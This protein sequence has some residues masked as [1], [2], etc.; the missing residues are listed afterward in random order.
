MTETT[1][2]LFVAAVPPEHVLEHL[3]EVV[4]P[5]RRSRPDLTWVAPRLLHVT[6]TFMPH[7]AVAVADTLPEAITAAARD[8]PPIRLSIAG[9][10]RFDERVLWAGVAGDIDALTAT[11]D[12]VARAVVDAGP[13][14]RG[15]YR[16]HVSLARASGSLDARLGPLAEQLDGYEGPVWQAD[17]LAL[18]RSHLGRS[19]HHEL[20]ATI[21][22]QG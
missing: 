20:L 22:L 6:V 18:V 17:E 14:R 1:Q 10:G 16:P 12:A 19:A 2:R 15:A 3:D 7:V 5:M 8:L 9:S 11:A 4:A 13:V 21:P